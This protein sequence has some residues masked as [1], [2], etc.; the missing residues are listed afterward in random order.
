M[1]FVHPFRKAL[2]NV[3]LGAILATGASAEPADV[4]AGFLQIVAIS[5]TTQAADTPAGSQWSIFLDGTIDAGAADRLA[6]WLAKRD[7]T[8][9]AVYLNSQ[10]GSLVAAMA[11]GRL[12]RRNGFATVVAA[13]S[14]RDGSV[15]AGVCYSACPF[16]FA[17][18]LPRALESGS[19]L[20]VHRAG[21]RVPIPDKSEFQQRVTHDTKF[22]LA[23]MGV[24]ERLVGIMSQVPDD[25]IRL[26]S[27]EEAVQ[28]K[29]VTVR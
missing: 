22:Y 13:R 5:P 29:L 19:M 7:I 18:G 4:S 27:V 28:L 9:A 6:G 20:G 15:V 14:A 11:L 1:S 21:H 8:S 23:E 25:A 17:G 3:A 24:D 2:R 26:L 10:G 16:A 12:F